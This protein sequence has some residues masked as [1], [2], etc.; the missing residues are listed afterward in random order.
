MNLEEIKELIQVMRKNRIG[1]IDLRQEGSRVRIIAG[2]SAPGPAYPAAMPAVETDRPR[3]ATPPVSPVEVYSDGVDEET[4][5][6]AEPA[7][8]V[9][10][11]RSPMVGTFYSAPAP[12]APPYV[13]IGSVVNPD[14]VLCIVEAM[15][16][17]N[18]VKAEIR[19]KICH[20]LVENGQPVEYNQPLFQV[21]P[22]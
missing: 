1:E 21:E 20:V 13:E 5:P 17:M 22:F 19:G 9:E 3:S 14:T 10:E 16:L 15:K 7:G 6:V 4:E 8:I 12:D 18:E 11:I 2:Q